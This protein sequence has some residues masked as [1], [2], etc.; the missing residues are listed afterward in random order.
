MGF[1]AGTV[2]V[3]KTTAND[4]SAVMEKCKYVSYFF[5]FN[6]TD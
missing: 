5:G 3:V 6:F 1:K 4:E 2:S